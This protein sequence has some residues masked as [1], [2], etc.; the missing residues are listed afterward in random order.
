MLA[1][2]NLLDGVRAEDL[3][4]A[5]CAWQVLHDLGLVPLGDGASLYVLYPLIP[6]I[7]VMA[8]G[9]LLGPV[10][11]LESEASRG[12]RWWLSFL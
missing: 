4:E 6:W 1:G 3:G 7:G 11:Q 2:H 8:A 9:Y 5:S 10:M 12:R